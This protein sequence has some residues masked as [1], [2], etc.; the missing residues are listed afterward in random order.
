MAPL[1]YT[2]YICN[3]YLF[4]TCHLSFVADNKFHEYMLYYYI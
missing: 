1:K 2:I 3:M 4:Q